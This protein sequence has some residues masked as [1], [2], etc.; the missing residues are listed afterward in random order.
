MT[1]YERAFNRL[2]HL[3]MLYAMAFLDQQEMADPGQRLMARDILDCVLICR[4]EINGITKILTDLKI[5]SPEEIKRVM[6]EQYQWL[7]GE[8]A[9]I[10]NVTIMDDGI[11][12]NKPGSQN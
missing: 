4:A 8:K 7:A 6:T 11:I 10:Y 1:E 12:I 9:K 2:H 5:V 3:S